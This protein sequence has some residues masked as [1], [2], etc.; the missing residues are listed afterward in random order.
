M[1]GIE[2]F[3]P[4]CAILKVAGSE[5]LDYVVDEAVQI[6]GCAGFNKEYPVEK[7]MRDARILRLYEGTSEI[8]RMII[9]RTVIDKYK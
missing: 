7:L 4:E 3:A 9:A 5:T 1:K 8:Q 2:Q 6:F